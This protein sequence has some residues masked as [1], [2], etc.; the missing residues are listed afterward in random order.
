MIERRSW[1][2]RPL[3][4]LFIL[5]GVTILS[6]YVILFSGTGREG[7]DEISYGITLRHY[8]SD[9]HE[10]ESSAAIPLEDALSSIPGINRIMTVS[11]N[12]KVRA[13]ATFRR[14]QRGFLRL[15]FSALE[16]EYCES[17]RE[18]A[19]RVYEA[20]PSSAQRPELSSSGDFRIPFWTAA[21]YSAGG[22][23]TDLRSEPDG[24][25]LERIIKP[26]LSSIEGIGEVEIAGSG[27]REI[28]ITLDQEKTAALGLS[29]ARISSVLGNNDALFLGG[30]F[31]CGSLEIPLR[32]DGRYRDLK[33]LEEALIPLDAKDFSTALL[34]TT[35]LPTVNGP[36]GTT[37]RLKNIADIRE[38][39]R[40]AE[41]LSRLN[42]KRT[43]VISVTAASGTDSG[44]LSNRIKK[45]IEK[46]SAGGEPGIFDATPAASAAGF[47]PLEFHVLEDRGAEEAAAFRSIFIAALEA[48]VLV[49][50]AAI[51][52][53]TGKKNY[54]R[55]GRL[56][57]GLICAGVIPL[58]LVVSAAILS[59]M[60]FPLNRKFLAGLAV[61]IGGAVD[62]VIL[63]A[64]GFGRAKHPGEG[65]RILRN[66]W[67]PLVSG[68]VTTIA[69]LIPLMGIGAAGDITV[70]TYAL[71]VV[72]IVALALALNLL[73][74]LFLK[75]LSQKRGGA[76]ENSEFVNHSRNY[77]F[78]TPLHLCVRYFRDKL[79]LTLLKKVRRHFTRFFAVLVRFC[80]KK[81]LV[82]PALLLL[83]SVT[84]VLGLVRAGADTGGEWVEDSVYAQVEF[85]GGF[86]KEEGD[87]LLASWAMDLKTHPAI[88]E[89]QTGARTGSG[90]ALVT[91]DH[92]MANV[93]EIRGLVRSKIIPG[94]FI[95]IPEPSSGD[96]IWDIS[97]SGDDAD[98]CRELARMAASLCSSIPHVRETVLNFKEGGP[99]LTL[100]PRRD[101]LAQGGVQFSYSADTVRRGV[102]GPVAYKRTAS[103]GEIDVRIRFGALNGDDVLRI[104]LATAGNNQGSL[105]VDS[106]MEAVRTREVSGIRRENRRRI[107]SFSIRTGPGDPRFFRDKTMEVLK[108]LELPQ[109]YR[110][111]F[112]PDAVRGAEALSG[113]FLNF[114]WAILL[115][116]MVIAAAEESFVL[117]LFILSSIPPS[118]A[119]PV[120][121]LILSGT[122]INA[123]AACALVAVSGMT[124]NASIISAGELWRL[125]T[126]EKSSFY[127]RLRSRI[128]ALLATTG[129]TIAGALPFLFLAEGS[130]A[131]VR[132]LALVTAL[133]VGASF[134]CSLTLV[135]S[136]MSF[137]FQIR[138]RRKHGNYVPHSRSSNTSSGVL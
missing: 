58:I 92:R 74:P 25:L 94:A 48:S 132:T 117:P 41:T 2:E 51:I 138:S 34:P 37:V 30:F 95:Y 78:F 50:L 80:V 16:D 27:I 79:A 40:E 85:E 109:G 66:I 107:A 127:R 11:E 19:Q 56:K 23:E 96:R 47:L 133:G 42:G 1:F 102:H 28:V 121:I 76:Y 44:I 135:P 64:E 99:R 114:I 60:G 131:L 17:V 3:A 77:A 128:P 15:G 116:Y 6:V 83:V 73:P 13:F 105:R 129:T 36:S 90:Y 113:K 52:L 100:V 130:N 31:R 122:P 111:E 67:P 89:V 70:I 8:G 108:D 115:C 35:L 126:S 103:G 18:A 118:L 110:I 72:T 22:S 82:F 65:K 55:N 10:M 84:A 26:A 24:A 119:I 120:L 53:G 68:A 4:A 39:E 136:W 104:P 33:A 49:A 98:K 45:E 124:V 32:L 61:G 57:N 63:S 59:A 14:S 137:Y 7:G 69:A 71:G 87:P 5:A 93:G 112:D 9:A 91:F 97:I 101:F 125:G 62:A 43:A 38:Q 81:P 20:L 88:R 29:P 12:G 21:V 54:S 134:F 106:F 46:F 75:D 86:L 123:A